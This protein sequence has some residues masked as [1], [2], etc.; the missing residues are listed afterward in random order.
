[1]SELE[2]LMSSADGSVPPHSL[3]AERAVLGAHL[4]DPAAI[5]EAVGIP[6]TPEDFYRDH[7]ARVYKAILALYER[8]ERADIITLKEELSKRGELETVGG[9]TELAR[10]LDYAG[11]TA[12]RDHH[13]RI[14]FDYTILRCIIQ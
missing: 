1:M 12:N 3:E 8:S 7:H 6:L 9:Q 4:R 11:T 14:W 5:S 2:T 10:L 13:A